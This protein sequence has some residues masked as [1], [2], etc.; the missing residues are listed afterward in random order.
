MRTSEWV[1]R[2][3]HCAN[4]SVDLSVLPSLLQVLV[5][6][7]VRDRGEEGHVG[8]A[9]RLLLEALLPVGLDTMCK[10]SR[11]NEPR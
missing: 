5:N 7:L 4:V 3:E 8:D 6:A 2:D 1:D 11:C 10:K 9:D